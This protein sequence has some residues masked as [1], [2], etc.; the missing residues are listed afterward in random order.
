MRDMSTYAKELSKLRAGVA[1]QVR[2]SSCVAGNRLL[3][4]L[5]PGEIERLTPHLEITR[6]SPK[7]PLC[8]QAYLYF[9]TTALV[10]II[11][12]LASGSTVEIGVI[13]NDGVVGL[14]TFLG[15]TAPGQEV[16]T[17]AGDAFRI[18]LA[19]LHAEYCR[20]DL[21]QRVLLRYSQAFLAQVAQA[22]V[23]NRFHSMEQRLCRWLLLRLDRLSSNEIA[24]TQDGIANMLGGRRAT[25]TVAAGHLQEM[26]LIVCY[27]GRIT[28]LDRSGLEA[29]VCECYWAVNQEAKSRRVGNAIRH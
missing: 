20:G 10:S 8:T 26:G 19:S 23:C 28:V 24:V 11:Y 22:A 15:G 13:G 5:S 21:L 2:K 7:T 16:C 25:V 18:K 29:A 9:P 14:N 6:I 17:L 3:T 27:R 1:S 12:T 4:Q